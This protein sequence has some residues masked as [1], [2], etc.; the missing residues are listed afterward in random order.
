MSDFTVKQTAEILQATTAIVRK[1][2]S[3]GLIKSYKVSERN[4]R[5]TQEAIDS[6]RNNGG[7]SATH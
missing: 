5:I 2:I 4:T 1:A 7:F 6:F 3:E